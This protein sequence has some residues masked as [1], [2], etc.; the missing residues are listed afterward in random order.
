MD[1]RPP[2]PC[3]WIIPIISTIAH[4]SLETVSMEVHITHVKEMDTLEL[5]ALDTLFLNPTLSNNSTKL[6]LSVCCIACDRV[7][8]EVV[9]TALKDG[10]PILDGKKRLEWKYIVFY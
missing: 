7:D 9:L 10:L 5:S 1:R 2:R 8:R 4:S 3:G 6:R